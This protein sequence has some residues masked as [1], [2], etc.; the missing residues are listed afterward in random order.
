MEFDFVVVANGLFSTPYIPTFRDQNKFA[1][2]IVH[3][4]DIKT[5]EQLENK[6]VIIVGGGKSATDLATV[7]GKYARS[8]HMIFRRSHWFVPP[9]ILHGYLPAIYLYSR[10]FTAIFDPFPSAPHSALYYFLHRKFQFVIDKIFKSMDDDI[11]ATYR[12]D[13]YDEKIFIPTYSFRNVENA[14]RMTDEFLKVKREGRIIRKLASIDEIVDETTIR[15]DSGE[16]L[17]ADLI[18]CATGFL[19]QV[20]FLSKTL[21]RAIGQNKITPT[22]NEGANLDLYRRIVPVGIPNITVIGYSAALNTWMLFEVQSHWTS[23]Y[24]LGRIKLPTN[25]KEMYE[26]IRTLRNFISKL[27][28]RKTYYI[29]YYWLEPIE[30]YLQDMGLSL[31]RTNNWISEYFGI[32]RPKRIANLHAERQAKAEGKAKSI[33]HRH[34]Y[35]SF[36]HTLLVLLFLLC[37]WLFF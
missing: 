1:G 21:S 36:G 15:L 26:E 9:T 25:E 16:T 11:L 14:S 8:C 5:Y 12:A 31:H 30:I 18:V 29:Q 24:F 3:A 2:S 19:E 37:I 28:N 13:I 35:F 20:C 33:W 7:A 17:Q 34:W 23:D 27:F 32:Y 22:S 10:M 4:N 6:R